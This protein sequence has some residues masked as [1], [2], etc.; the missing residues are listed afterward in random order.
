MKFDQLRAVVLASGS[1]RRKDY[2]NRY[3]FEFDIIT[4]DI[5]ESVSPGE[6]P[7]TFAQR[8]AKEKAEAVQQQCTAGQIIIAADTIVVQ[9]E[10][11]LGKPASQKDILPALQLLNGKNHQVMTAYAVLDTVSGEMIQQLVSTEVEFFNL[12]EEQLKCYAASSEPLDKAGSYSIQGVGTFLVKSIKGSYNNV[13]GLPI[14][15]LLQDL[16]KKEYIEF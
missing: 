6:S 3:G 12:P 16:A 15:H 5:D 8:L 9:G 1:P 2:L 7:E 4:A 13:V 14:E 11:I 10:T